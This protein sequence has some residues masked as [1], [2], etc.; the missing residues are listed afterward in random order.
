MD[1]ADGNVRLLVNPLQDTTIQHFIAYQVT[2]AGDL[3][4]GV[5]MIA[6]NT[7]GLIT[8]TGNVNITTEG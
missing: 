2:F 7:D 6:E 5:P 1:V 4:L 3:G 8:E